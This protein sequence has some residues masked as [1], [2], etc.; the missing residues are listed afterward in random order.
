MRTRR[1]AEEGKKQEDK[2]RAF[3]FEIGAFGPNLLPAE[4]V[5]VESAPSRVSDGQNCARAAGKLPVETLS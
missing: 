4:R 3:G 1:K 2:R 5:A